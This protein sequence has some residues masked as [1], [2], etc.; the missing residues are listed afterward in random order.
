MRKAT[1]SALLLFFFACPAS[2]LRA[3]DVKGPFGMDQTAAPETSSVWQEWKKIIAAADIEI[4]KLEKCRAEKNCNVAEEKYSAIVK[5][6]RP[7]EPY[8]KVDF[9]QVRINHEIQYVADYTQ[10]GKA[11]RWSLPVDGEGK[12]SLNT[13]IGDCEDY[14]LAKYLV[15]LD[16][17]YPYKSMRILLVR[18]NFVRQD[19]AVLAVNHEGKWLILDNRW[20]RL[21]EDQHL[22][23]FKPLMAVDADGVHYLNKMFRIS[24]SYDP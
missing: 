12:G 10:W 15:L 1:A 16:A 11:D 6:A 24:D 13:G 14:V 17:L 18:D 2:D 3:A 21:Y 19:H 23:Q 9:V 22:K 4:Q 7:K 20:D 5:E 8:P